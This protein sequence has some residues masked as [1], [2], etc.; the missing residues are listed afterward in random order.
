MSD[1]SRRPRRIIQAPPVAP[2]TPGAPEMPPPMLQQRFLRVLQI[3][4]IRRPERTLERHADRA[5]KPA[6]ELSPPIASP[7]LPA[8][9]ARPENPTAPKAD[10]ARAEPRKPSDSALRRPAEPSPQDVWSPHDEPDAWRHAGLS[11][12]APDHWDGELAQRIVSLCRQADPA[13]QSWTITVPMDPAV[14]PETELRLAM[15]P[16]AMSLRFHTHSPYSQRLVLRHRQR[17]VAQL[18]QALPAPA[19]EIDVDLM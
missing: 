14:L 5:A 18:A 4:S 3:G 11:G 10:D 16:H 15:S 8:P 6:P 1:D 19:R 2:A 17:L 7:P 9:A 13:M 12:P